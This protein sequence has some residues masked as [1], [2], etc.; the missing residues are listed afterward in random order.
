S[1]QELVRLF[2]GAGE[3]SRTAR[4][5]AAAITAARRQTPLLRTGQL[6]RVVEEAVDRAHL[7]RGTSHPATRVFLALRNRVSNALPILKEGIR[8]AA[9]AL[10]PAG[11]LCIISYFGSEHALVKKTLREL[12]R[13]CVCPPRLPICGCGRKP[14]IRLLVEKAL[15]PSFCEVARNESARSARLHVARRT[16]TVI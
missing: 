5:I 12:E 15:S 7:R 4:V 6:A 8:A 16:G 11:R 3:S 14:V 13:G 1:E 10:C 9:Q 2:R